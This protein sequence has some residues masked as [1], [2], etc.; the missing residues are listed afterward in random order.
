MDNEFTPHF[1][2]FDKHD[3][4]FLIR[5]SNREASLAL[6]VIRANYNLYFSTVEVAR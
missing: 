3:E 2:K 6:L 1:G 4:M 5:G